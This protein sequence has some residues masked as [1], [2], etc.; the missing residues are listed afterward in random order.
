MQ[1]HIND[2]K[3]KILNPQIVSN[4]T[5]KEEN[6]PNVNES[7]S[8]KVKPMNTQGQQPKADF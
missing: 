1:S 4:V 3:F 6:N 7:L 2:T 8:M 5:A